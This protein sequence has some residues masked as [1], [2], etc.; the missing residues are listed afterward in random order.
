[1]L[2]AKQVTRTSHSVI[3]RQI[4]AEGVHV[5]PF[6]SEF[7]LDIRFLTI[8]QHAVPMNR[9]DYFELVY[10]YSGE[11]TL[12]VQERNVVIKQGDLF[13]MG[14]TLF[15]RPVQRRGT[16]LQAV[17][18]YFLPELIYRD[19]TIDEEA[20]DY[21]MPFLVQDGSFNH[22]VLS[23]TG[24]PARVLHWIERIHEELPAA[25]SQARLSAK[26]YLRMILMLLGKHYRN[27]P[28]SKEV[29]ARKKRDIH[30]L[31][32]LFELMDE[33][34]TERISLADSSAKVGMSKS[35][36]KRFFRGVTG[37]TFITYLS[38]FRI[39]KAQALLAS[40]DRSIAEISQ[41]VG[42]C[43]QSYFGVVFQKFAHMSPYQYR[44]R[45]LRMQENSR[46]G[47]ARAMPSEVPIESREAVSSDAVM[48]RTLKRGV[49]SR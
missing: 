44:K 35:H 20:V 7:P 39:A 12:Q 48:V 29:F 6:D 5:W 13:I 25:S 41:E 27:A 30:R 36:F 19:G 3:E 38:R 9:H 46:P 22:V 42:F 26:T 11:A 16:R 1:V 32:P 18:V 40:T 33:R 47:R 14:S 8:D 4:S 31:G 15:H 45:R 21:L 23:E 24:L 10:C 49:W 28:G 43:S 34:Y 17:V 37:Q 2:K